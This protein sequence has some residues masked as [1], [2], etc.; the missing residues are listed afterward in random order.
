MD[1]LEPTLLVIPLLAVLAPLLARLQDASRWF[2]GAVPAQVRHGWA[3]LRDPRRPAFAVGG[4]PAASPMS[5]WAIAN[6]VTESIMHRTERPESR[7]DSASAR[8]R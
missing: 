3:A 7:N 5:R 4:S 6:R 8:V 1:Q 2:S